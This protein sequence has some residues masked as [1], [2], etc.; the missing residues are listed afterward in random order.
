MRSSSPESHGPAA[1]LQMASAAMLAVPTQCS[2]SS[3]LVK[4]SAIF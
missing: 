4:T 2:S 1:T 3:I